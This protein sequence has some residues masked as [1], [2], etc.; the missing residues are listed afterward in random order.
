MND[1]ISLT[2]AAERG[3]TR[4]R[5]PKWVVPMD[6]VRLDIVEGLPSPLLRLHSPMNRALNGRD[7]VEIPVVDSAAEM[8]LNEKSWLPYTGPLPGSDEYKAEAERWSTL[9]ENTRGQIA[10]G[11]IG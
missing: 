4:L 3:I 11:Q 1:L 10:R 9:F 7:P 6:H 5:R 2:E 8:N